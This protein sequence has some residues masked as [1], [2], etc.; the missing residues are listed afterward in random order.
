MKN[1]GLKIYILCAATALILAGCQGKMEVQ[2]AGNEAAISTET[3]NEETSQAEATPAET[4]QTEAVEKE[5]TQPE[6][7]ELT[8]EEKESAIYENLDWDQMMA[9]TI[10]EANKDRYPG[11]ECVGEGHIILDTE[12]EENVMTVYALT[13]YGEYQFHNDDQFVKSAGSGVIPCVLEFMVN[14]KGAYKWKDIAWPTDGAGFVES[15]HELF[16]EEWW[17]A[18]ITPSEDTKAELIKQERVY[19]QDYLLSIGRDAQIGDYSDF[20]H[21]M[22][23]E[24][25]VSVEASNALLE[26]EKWIGNYPNWVGTVETLENETRYVY[27]KAVDVEVGKIVLTKTEYGSEEPVEIHE[28]DWQTGEKL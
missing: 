20:E 7:K 6:I 17:D 21:V 3:T 23:T 2:K 28:F 13:M 19:A 4:K 8:P 5:T 14:E 16:P 12:L 1:R 11:Y 25:G 27:E 15:V 18:C 26:E 10:M 24:I 22:M 9:E